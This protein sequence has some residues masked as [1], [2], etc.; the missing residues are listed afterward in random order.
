M[1]DLVIKI[2]MTRGIQRSYIISEL[3]AIQFQKKIVGVYN[4]IL[5]K[6]YKEKK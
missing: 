4:F 5:C 3:E 1:K 6:V 2:I